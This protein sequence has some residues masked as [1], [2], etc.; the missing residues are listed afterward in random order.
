M[1]SGWVADLVGYKHF[2]V[3]VICSA[4]PGFTLALRLKV[5]AGFG[6]KAVERGA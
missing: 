4:L 3:W 6:K 1:W 5:D 2:F